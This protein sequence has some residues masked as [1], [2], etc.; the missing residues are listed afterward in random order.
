M[1]SSEENPDEDLGN[2]YFVN[3]SFPRLFNHHSLIFHK[4]KQ[5]QYFIKKTYSKNHFNI[6]KQDGVK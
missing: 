5:S 6:I 2:K 4:P 1:L 3:Y